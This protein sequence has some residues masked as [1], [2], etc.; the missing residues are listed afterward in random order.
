MLVSHVAKTTIINESYAKQA[1]QLQLQGMHDIVLPWVKNIELCKTSVLIAVAAGPKKDLIEGQY[2]HYIYR[3][4]GIIDPINNQHIIYV[5]MLTKQLNTIDSQCLIGV[6]KEKILNRAIAGVMLGNPE[7][8]NQDVLVRFAPNILQ[9]LCPHYR[10]LKPPITETYGHPGT[11]SGDDRKQVAETVTNT[12]LVNR[13]TCP[14]GKYWGARFY[15]PIAINENH[16][17]QLPHANL[18]R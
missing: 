13:K 18:K 10:M 16:E 7:A 8:M 3:E 5:E 9:R 11:L 4:Q 15:K 6:L 14:L 12:A 17:R 1:T 2:F